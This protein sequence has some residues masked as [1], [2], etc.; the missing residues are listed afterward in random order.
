M[1][2]FLPAPLKGV[3]VVLLILLNT[4]IFL[5]FLLLGHIIVVCVGVKKS[6]I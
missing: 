2:D 4:L 1:L 3:L 5:P 6:R